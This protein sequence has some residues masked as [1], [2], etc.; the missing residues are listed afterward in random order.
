MLVPVLDKTALNALSWIA[1]CEKTITSIKVKGLHDPPAPGIA[2]DVDV[3]AK[4]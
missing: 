3:M 2:V 4:Y 1:S